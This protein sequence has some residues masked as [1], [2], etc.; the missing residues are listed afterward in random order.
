M[1]KIPYE[2]VVAKITAEAGISEDELNEKIEEKL[3][4]LSGLVSKEGAAH[5]IANELGVKILEEA[6]GRLSVAKILPGMRSVE[7]LGKVQKV[8]DL[9]KFDKG[10]KKGQV[11]SFVAGDETGTIR[12]VLWNDQ[13]ER[14]ETLKEGDIVHIENAYVKENNGQ[15]EIHLGEKSKIE[16][17]PPGETI[18]EVKVLSQSRIQ[19][20]IEKLQE[21]DSNVEILGTI[22]Q[23]FEPRYFEVCPDCNKRARMIAGGTDFVCEVHGRIAPKY[24]YVLNAILDDG[25]GTIRVVF[26]KNQAENLTGKSEQDL[27]AIK[28]DQAKIEQLKNDLLGEIVKIVGRAAKNTMFDRLEFVSQ[29]VFA[30]PDPEEE[31][32]RLEQ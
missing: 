14:I 8:F 25:S 9:K 31:L 15:K 4:Q 3:Q 19:K 17:N 20:K 32:Q 29:L 27:I 24:S 16:I 2:D 23:T 6:Q 12:V 28:D 21:G 22:V 1:I 7:F 13:V 5:I 11:R 26:F 18:G 30:K 10:T